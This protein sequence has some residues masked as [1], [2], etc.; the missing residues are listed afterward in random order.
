MLWIVSMEAQSNNHLKFSLTFVTSVRLT[1]YTTL[2]LSGFNIFMKSSSRSSKSTYS[3]ASKKSSFG[4]I[5][6][7]ATVWF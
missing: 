2:T 1:L 7:V 6:W 4:M 5:V 3:M